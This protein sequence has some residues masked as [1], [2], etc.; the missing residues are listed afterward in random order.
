MDDTSLWKKFKNIRQEISNMKIAH[1][2]GLGLIDFYNKT[3][4]V[5]AYSGSAY[6]NY[7]YITATAASDAVVPFFIQ[8]DFS[9]HNQSANVIQFTKHS[10]RVYIWRIEDWGVASGSFRVFANATC[11][12]TITSRRADS[13]SNHSRKTSSRLSVSLPHSKR[14]NSRLRAS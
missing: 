13:L 3:H 9:I 1:E 6:V 4:T 8:L 2:R 7:I 10:D 12:F 11:D 14:R 5:S